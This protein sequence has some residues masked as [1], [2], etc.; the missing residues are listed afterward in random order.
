MATLCLD[1][2]H[3][4]R[5]AGAAREGLAEKAI[6][7]DVALAACEALR[8]SHRVVLTRARDITLS[9]A[10]RR[11][12][13]ERARADLFLSIHVNASTGTRAEGVEAFVRGPADEASR[14]LAAAVLRE[15]LRRWPDRRNRG[16]KTA[17]LGV[18]RQPRP[19]VLVE[20]FFLSHPAERALLRQ[21][22][23]RAA[24]GRAIGRGCEV[25][26]QRAPVSARARAVRAEANRGRTGRRA[27]RSPRP[28]GSRPV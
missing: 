24:L 7:L 18:L 9:L 23:A 22:A 14:A 13:A 5:D 1:P 19:A 26:L 21:L 25:F 4:G 12:I 10:D 17:A 6:T 20:C 28:R 11:R 16:I 3:G 8:A 27:A 15:I 2:G